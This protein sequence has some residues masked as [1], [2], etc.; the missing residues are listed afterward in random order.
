MFTPKQYRE[1][2]AQYAELAR[3]GN[4]PNVVREFQTHERSLTM[5]ADN[6]QWLTDN[7]DKLA[8]N[9]DEMVPVLNP[10]GASKGRLAAEEGRILR[11]LGAAL[12]M[13]WNVLPTGLQRDLFDD[14]GSKGE[15]LETATPRGQI[16]RFLRHHADGHNKSL[17]LGQGSSAQWWPRPR[18]A[19]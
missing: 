12:I 7:D 5:L 6:K 19:T 2:A 15:Q 17:P 1:K 11:C 8:N 16:A 9:L 10:S 3:H 14:A 4:T 18:I 13:E